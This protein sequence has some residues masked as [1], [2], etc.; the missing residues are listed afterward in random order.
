MP[1]L[2]Q[3]VLRALSRSLARSTAQCD[4]ISQA[5]LACTRLDQ[6]AVSVSG[7]RCTGWQRARDAERRL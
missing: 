2:A 5:A 3:P 1:Q 7:D 4:A 6:T